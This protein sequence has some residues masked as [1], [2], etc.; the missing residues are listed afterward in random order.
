MARSF[1]RHFT[2]TRWPSKNHSVLT[3]LGHDD[4]AAAAV[5]DSSPQVS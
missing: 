3:R 4:V 2:L 1:P 5:P